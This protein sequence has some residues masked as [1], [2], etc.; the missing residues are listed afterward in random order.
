MGSAGVT[1]NFHPPPAPF[2]VADRGVATFVFPV[3]VCLVDAGGVTGKSSAAAESEAARFCEMLELSEGPA[4]VR[5][6]RL[7][8]KCDRN[9]A[10]RLKLRRGKRGHVPPECWRRGESAAEGSLAALAST[11][12][13]RVPCVCECPR[14]F[15]SCDPSVLRPALRL[16]FAGRPP[17]SLLCSG[18]STRPAGE[19]RRC[20]QPR[21]QAQREHGL[22][23]R[24]W[25]RRRRRQRWV[26]PSSWT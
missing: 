4:S 20:G 9:F 12:S 26:R 18:G 23:R 17:P 16:P 1:G 15:P 5:A 14:H 13:S 3:D 6:V 10:E 21:C 2:F 7:Y 24:G 19:P 25:W 22:A 8:A 11:E